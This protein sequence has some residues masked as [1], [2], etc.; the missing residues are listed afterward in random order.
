MFC[1]G[2]EGGRGWVGQCG[3]GQWR[4]HLG[5]R[6]GREAP[7]APVSRSHL[8]VPHLLGEL[9]DG[10][11]AVLLGAAGGE[12]RE[13]HHEE[14]ETGEG[15][16]VHGELAEV[17]VELA[18]EAQAAGDA[19][20]DGRD[21]V[22]EVAERGRG[23]L[24]GAEADVVQGLVVK[25]H[26]L[27]GV[28]DQLVHGQRGVVGLHHRVG[29]LGRR[30]HREG[31]HDAVGVLL[32]DL[33]DE[34]R[35]HAGARAAAERVA[36]LEALEAVAGLGLLAHHVQHRVD[37][38]G[39]L[40]VV[41]LGPVVARARLAEDEVVGAEDLAVGARADRVLQGRPRGPRSRSRRVPRT[42]APREAASRSAGGGKRARGRARPPGG[43]RAGR[44]RALQRPRPI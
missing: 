17:G 34:Q 37:Q 39:A 32:A 4:I 20:H 31:A 33:G 21:E 2:G 16:E 26:A 40:R 15:D 19:R 13:A 43:R 14:V 3:R 38:L 12:G 30:H 7:A 18:G 24:E 42:R 22:V 10:E 41:A 8:G 6:Q 29:H 25:H 11:G 36:D 27:V 44:R 28:L 9:G 23:E 5:S 35:A 1:G